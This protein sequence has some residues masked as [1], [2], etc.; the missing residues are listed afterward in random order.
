M[1]NILREM[2]FEKEEGEWADLPLTDRF[3]WLDHTRDISVS[4]LE[5]LPN[6]RVFKCHNHSPQEMDDLFFKG[7]HYLTFSKKTQNLD[8]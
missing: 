3:P 4:D 5:K 7:R 2:L 6:P 8:F 1:Q